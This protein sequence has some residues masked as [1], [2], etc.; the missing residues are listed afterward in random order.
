MDIQQHFTHI[1]KIIAETAEACHRSPESVLLLAV[2]K[3]QNESAIREAHQLGINDFAE[4][5]FQEG[6]A[7]IAA[8][9]DLAITW[10]FIGPIQSNKAKGI[11]V[12]YN[13]VHSLNRLEVANSLNEHRTAQLPPLNVC[14]QINLVAEETKSGIAPSEALELAQAVSRLP[15]LRLRGLMT[16][17]PPMK[18]AAEQYELYLQLNHLMHSLNQQ[19]PI[20]MDTLSMGMSDDFIPAIQAGSTIVRIGQALFGP[21]ERKSL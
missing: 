9:K 15:Q 16:I 18:N 1:K 20:P 12:N 10:H 8:L 2:S 19:L 17:P 3:Q 11:A 7:K 21:R 6:Q 13:W 14:L 5:Y 4:N